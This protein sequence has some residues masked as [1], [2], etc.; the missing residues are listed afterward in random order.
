MIEFAGSGAQRSVKI[1]KIGDPAYLSLRLT[2][3]RGF[4][5]EGVAVKARIGACRTVRQVVRRV[6]R[7][8]LRD[9]KNLG[10]H[11]VLDCNFQE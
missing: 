1:P 5:T 9:L 11:Q 4:Y 10:I 8:G 7:C 2:P 6:E 3:Y